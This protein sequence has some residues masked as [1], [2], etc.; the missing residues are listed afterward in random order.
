[1]AAPGKPGRCP[2]ADPAV[3]TLFAVLRHPPV[4]FLRGA[5][6]LVNQLH[7]RYSFRTRQWNLSTPTFCAHSPAGMWRSPISQCVPHAREKG[8]S[9]TPFLCRSES[10]VADTLV[11]LPRVMPGIMNMK[12]AYLHYACKRLSGLLSEGV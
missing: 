8:N 4:T 9:Q 12:T 5:K 7:R 6:R 2:I 3:W 10:P 1:M 11:F